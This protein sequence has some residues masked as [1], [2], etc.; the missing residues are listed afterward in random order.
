MVTL[1]QPFDFSPSLLEPVPKTCTF[2]EITFLK[3]Y[4]LF[5]GAVESTTYPQN[6]LEQGSVV[7][8]GP[9]F[10]LRECLLPVPTAVGMVFGGRG[11][12]LETT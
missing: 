9:R 5:T 10:R 3:A 2:L 12:S 4:R 6:E 7:I 8:H 11:P 1:Q